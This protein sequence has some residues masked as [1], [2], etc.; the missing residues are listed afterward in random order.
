MFLCRSGSLATSFTFRLLS[1]IKGT[2][3]HIDDKEV[4]LCRFFYANV[5]Y[6]L[7]SLSLSVAFFFLLFFSFLFKSITNIRSLQIWTGLGG[8]LG[9]HFTKLLTQQGSR[10]AFKG[11]IQQMVYISFYIQLF[12]CD[13][14]RE[15]TIQK[16]ILLLPLIVL[17]YQ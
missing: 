14:R 8:A 5:A 11:S 16:G 12:I 6:L 10:R 4:K 15:Y 7:I 13:I 1:K 17:T 3:R 2:F 9:M